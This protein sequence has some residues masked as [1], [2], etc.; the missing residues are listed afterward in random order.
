MNACQ[1]ARICN[2]CI[3]FAILFQI[4]FQ[5]CH[6]ALIASG[7]I[8][9]C[10]NQDGIVENYDCSPKMVVTLTLTE[11]QGQVES[12]QANLYEVRDT[13]GT[14]RKLEYPVLITLEKTDV[15]QTY[16][17]T[18]LRTF[19]ADLTER[20]VV[21]QAIAGILHPCVDTGDN[22][23]CGFAYTQYVFSIDMTKSKITVASFVLGT[24]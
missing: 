13:D 21:K 19:A 4:Q 23:D 16:P 5:L 2:S 24:P 14:S 9:Q 12:L 6:N 3:L 18:Y 11:G 10:I 20:I 17:L 8:E 7:Q 15:F 22:P 1:L